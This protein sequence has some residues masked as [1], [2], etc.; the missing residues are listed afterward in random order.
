VTGGPGTGGPN[1]GG[2]NA[3][4]PNAGGP[5]AGGPNA[6]GP[7]TGSTAP[8]NAGTPPWPGPADVDE[9]TIAVGEELGSGGQ[10]TVYRVD[11]RT[12]LVFKR[13]KVTGADPGALK[14]LVDL[15]AQ[16]QPSERGRLYARAAWPLAR[17]YHKG[18]L[19][20]FLMQ[21]IPARFSAA[22]DA[23]GVR[24]REIQ[25]LV[26]PRKPLWGQ[27]VPPGG[28]SAQTRIAVAR[29]FTQL[30]TLL[31][32]K[33]L[34]VGDVSIRNVL[35]TGTDGAPVT[36][37]LIDCDGIRKL[38]SRPVLS[39]AE[40]LDWNDPRQPA[41]GPNLDTDRYKLALLVGRVLSVSAYVRPGQPLSLVPDIPS[42]IATRVTAAW[43]QAAGPAG[44]RPD[45]AQWAMALSD[46]EEIVLAPPP[47]V[48]QSP[49][50][51]RQPLEGDPG[52][53]RPVIKLRPDPGGAT[54]S[55]S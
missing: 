53:S 17:V 39:Q 6:G 7:N 16:L 23:G 27:I 28:V 12:G 3:G 54:A 55:P 29:E 25:F 45:S 20:G 40:T 41:S 51:P 35:W 32:D 18:Q 49:P 8:G 38:G 22:N 2:P 9:A 5:N 36:I 42:R 34:I 44:R 14:I 11:G 46:R 19:S 50:L 24:L 37:F 13:Y 31:H 47:P 26:Y 21:E 1:T 33:A 52:Q 30:I 43:Q 48:R 15:P 4:G 10:G